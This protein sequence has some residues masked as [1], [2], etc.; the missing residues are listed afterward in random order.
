MYQTRPRSVVVA[1]P[2]GTDP[3]SAKLRVELLER[4]L[5]RSFVIPGMN[6]TI[7]LDAWL[8]SFRCWAMS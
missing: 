5:E 6:I 4:L 2:L 7:G 8:G 3:A 1:R